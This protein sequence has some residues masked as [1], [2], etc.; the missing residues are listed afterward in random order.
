MNQLNHI[1]TLAIAFA[2]A[3]VWIP[4]SLVSPTYG[5]MF[6]VDVRISFS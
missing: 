6:A 1:K 4:M 5:S 2:F 3:L